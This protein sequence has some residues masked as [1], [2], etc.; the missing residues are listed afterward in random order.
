MPYYFF[1]WNDENIAHLAE[2]GVTPDEFEQIVCDPVSE[3]VSRSTGRPVAFGL[4][5]DGRRLM[6]VYEMVDR[7]TVLPITAYEVEV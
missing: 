4:A 7:N 6:C 2:H 3:D 1:I 5:D